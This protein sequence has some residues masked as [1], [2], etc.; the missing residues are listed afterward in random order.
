MSD[1]NPFRPITGL[2]PPPSPHR[3]N[4]ED[5]LPSPEG[6][7]RDLSRDPLDEEPGQGYLAPSHE[8]RSGSTPPTDYENMPVPVSYLPPGAQP[9]Q[10]FYGALGSGSLEPASR[11]SF[12]SSSASLGEFAGPRPGYA[13]RDSD[14]NSVSKLRPD[15]R[16]EGSLATYGADPGTPR[17]SSYG[18]YHDDPNMTGTEFPME[19]LQQTHVKNA[20]YAAPSDQKRKRVRW[21]LILGAVVIVLAIAAVMVYLFVIRKDTSK[22]SS[23]GGTSSSSSH[24]SSTVS[25]GSQPRFPVTGGDGSTVTLEDGTTFVYKNQFGGTWYYDPNDPHNNNAQAQ[26]YSPALNKTW[27]YGT[28]RLY[29]YVFR[30]PLIYIDA[31]P[32]S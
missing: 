9:P 2:N 4:Y 31:P 26:S 18:I 11:D 32:I 12:A 13:Y 30:L 15:S 21:L 5:E 1:T 14:Y 20:M 27:K 23:G 7:S 16:T 19:D 8:L 10:R 24:H 25:S 17:M 6:T 28:D 29:G 22:S 3:N